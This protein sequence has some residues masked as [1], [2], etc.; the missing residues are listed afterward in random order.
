MKKP[1][2][3][4]FHAGVPFSKDLKGIGRIFF[5]LGDPVWFL[6]Y[7]VGQFDYTFVFRGEF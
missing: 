4:K 6:V 7:N 1:E 2:V 5:L 3:K